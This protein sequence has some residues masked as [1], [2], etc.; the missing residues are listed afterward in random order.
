LGLVNYNLYLTMSKKKLTISAVVVIVGLGALLYIY[1]GFLYKD[2]RNISSEESAFTIGADG[3]ADAYKANTQS[4]DAKYLNKAIEIE[5]MVTEVRDSVMILDSVV[6]CG[7]DS[8]PD[9]NSI[10][11]KITIKGRCI[12]FDELFGE[13]KLDQCTLKNN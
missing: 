7:F 11:K 3:L 2:A 9:K 12:G 8:M 5:G 10:N 13:V 4:A 6:F 1:Y